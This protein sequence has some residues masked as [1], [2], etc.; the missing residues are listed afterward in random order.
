M[1][2][3]FIA[4][5]LLL[6]AIASV[7]SG[8]IISISGQVID[9][10]NPGNPIAN[11]T[12]TLKSSGTDTFTNVS[13]QF[14]LSVNVTATILRQ[15]LATDAIKIDGS[16][17]FFSM[18]MNE[19]LRV[20][21]Y[22]LQ[23]RRIGTGFNRTFG[24][25]VYSLPLTYFLGKSIG[26][27]LVMM[28]ITKG[29]E[30]LVHICVPLSTPSGLHIGSSGGGAV[31]PINGGDMA[32]VPK[33]G[34][35]VAAASPLD[36]L[37][38]TRMGY[39]PAAV[40]L[41]SYITQNVGTIVLHL[42]PTEFSVWH[43]ADSVLALM[44][45]TQKAGQ[46][47]EVQLNNSSGNGS[48]GR[49]TNQ[50]VASMCIGSVF[51]GGSD[52]V[53]TATG[54]TPAGL[55]GCVD[56]AQSVN[57]S[58]SALKIPFIYGQDVIH[59]VAEIYGCTVFPQNIGL[60]CTHDSA[61]VDK[62]GQITAL[63]A[64]GCGIRLMF[65][66]TV[67][68]PRDLRW[69][70]TFEGFG[71]EPTDNI[72]VGLAEMRGEQGNGNINQNT[73]IACCIKHYI[74]DGGTSGG[75]NA[76]ND[77]LTDST[78]Q[79]LHFPQ[80][81]VGSREGAATVMI[82]YSGWY[83]KP[84][85]PYFHET[86]DSIAM[87]TMLKKE[88]GFM[89]FTISDW[90]ALNSAYACE[91]YTA[92]CV[93]QAVNAG[94]DMAMIVGSSNPSV[95][96]DNIVADVT[97]GTIPQARVDDA[98]RRILRTKFRMGLFSHPY[99]DTAARAQI[100]SASSQAVARQLVRES[101]VLLQNNTVNGAAVLPLESTDKIVV[102]GPYANEMGAQCGGWTI[103]WQGSA[104]QT[105][106]AGQTILAGL[107]SVGGTANVTYDQNATN[108][109]SENPAK[110]IL[111]LGEIPYAEGDGDN[112]DNVTLA[113]E[114]NY[115]LLSTCYQSGKPVILILLSGRPLIL[116]STDLSEVKGLVAAWLPSSMGI[117]V[118]DVLYG[119]SYNFTGTLTQTWPA[120]YGQIPIHGG[121]VYADEP[122]GSGGTPLYPYGYGLHY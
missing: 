53:L 30:Q 83:R 62:M 112:L 42:T 29:D 111:V 35:T 14:T 56:S 107:Q 37:I 108:L 15:V 102:V 121:E 71:E 49:L 80:Y 84:S 47:T 93:A 61:L 91:N 22:T 44:N 98:V 106:I 11:A 104:T 40:P 39:L 92:S 21:L 76:G 46:M 54:N 3:W 67:T 99:S 6:A 57:M 94:L 97:N 116:S 31:A 50:Q 119:G 59:G 34:I 26:A 1:R 41:S 64:A 12:V 13:G 5:S 113:N 75:V 52:A 63:E 95:W 74:G 68:T 27:G 72:N 38:V 32:A 23:G 90:D 81:V 45:N 86:L 117:G 114:A 122:H 10:M 79:A 69:G 88:A 120:S 115:S 110:I 66:P 109:A 4:F 77:S 48:G 51:N 16:M 65:G 60:G 9:T 73:A 101:L 18:K 82:S 24:E 28:K 36:S 70:R 17:L 25:G 43:K 20:D 105:G 2:K 78:M 100:F 118:A 85:G 96:I 33:S 55:A 103:S 87:G 19:R 7:A 89:G 58:Q 8:G